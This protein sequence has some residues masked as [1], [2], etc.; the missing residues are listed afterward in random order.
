MKKVLALVAVLVLMAQL[1]MAQGFNASPTNWIP[2]YTSNGTNM[3][4][5]IASVPF[6]SAS[7]AATSTG[8]VRQIVFAIQ[9][10]IYQ[11]WLTI[12]SSNQSDRITVSRASTVYSNRITYIYTYR[13]DVVPASLVVMPE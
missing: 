8:D 11:K 3:V 4:I 5:P 13:V 6:L 1:G 2:G 10:A 7:Q 9:E 12:P